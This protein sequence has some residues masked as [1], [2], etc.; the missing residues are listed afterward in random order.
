METFGVQSDLITKTTYIYLIMPYY[1]YA[2]E[3]IKVIRS[4]CHKTRT[5]WISEQDAI[6]RMFQKQIIQILYNSP[7]ND[8]TIEVLKRGDKYKLF[9]LKIDIDT[10][11]QHQLR[12]FY[13]MLDE[14]PEFEIYMIHTRNCNNE[15]IDTLAKKP[16]FKT[17]KD[18][19]KVLVFGNLDAP[20]RSESY[21]YL[22]QV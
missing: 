19:L 14:M 13:R 21:E 15:L 6:I 11:D 17:I 5:I 2:Y 9:K 10:K 7:I 3:S 1:D 8:K 18:L 20:E 12:M 22:L 16:T 4:L